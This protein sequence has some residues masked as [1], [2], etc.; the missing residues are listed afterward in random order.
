LQDTY[1]KAT[2]QFSE[3]LSEIHQLKNLNSRQLDL[4]NLKNNEIDELKVS[5][6]SITN[7]LNKSLVALGCKCRCRCGARTNDFDEE[8]DDIKEIKAELY[9]LREE[10][11]YY[12]SQLEEKTERAIKLQMEAEVSEERFVRSKAFKSLVSQA[13]SIIKHTETL[14]KTNE[15]LQK[16]NDEFNEAKN[17][18][19]RNIIAREEEK[20]NSIESQIQSM[21]IKLSVLER[22]KDEALS[23]IKVLTKE[24]AH[25]ELSSNYKYI[26]EDLEEEKTRLKRQLAEYSKE[27]N[28]A[29]AR[30]EE[31][32]KKNNELK[33]LLY[34]K[35]IDTTKPLKE[36]NYAGLNDSELNV[37]LKEYRTEVNEL[38]NQLKSKEL[39]LSKHESIIRQLK[40][41]LKI[42]K[43]TNES[44]I[45]EIEVT[46][47]AYEETMKKNKSLAAQL[48]EQ[49][50]NCIQLMNERL[51]EENLK[52]LIEKQHGIYEEQL[53]SKENLIAQLKDLIKEEQKVSNAR[54]EIIN[55]LDSKFKTLEQRIG[56]MN[57]SHN[58]NNRKYE[59]LLNCKKELQEKLKEAEK[60]C[61]KNATECVQ[62]KFLYEHSE[63]CFRENEERMVLIRES[64]CLKTNDEIFMA[65]I[66]KYRELIRCSQCKTRN[67]DCLITKCLHLFCRRCI[68]WNLS[69]K[70]RKCPSCFTK[71][72]S[73]DVRTFYWS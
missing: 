52:T 62:Y 40:Q 36:E 45:N 37:R 10:K 16:T 70:K 1:I 55:S 17:K 73:E 72:S 56:S 50:Q 61:I 21:Q 66:T 53:E 30:L 23:K 28:E 39:A 71:F 19:I 18:E 26:I 25:R 22:E 4:I 9:R 6:E 42:E 65:E 33:D 14:K 48:V 29:L 46:G 15:E 49:E 20:R 63:R 68:E 64:Q 60:I 59:E 11:K 51:K 2:A 43:R 35:E 24:K 34:L 57:A 32:Q 8:Y 58:E 38:K 44:L 54:I 41:D 7:R 47:N 69:Q 3:Y 31:E 12:S 67:K 5:K 13:R 27:K